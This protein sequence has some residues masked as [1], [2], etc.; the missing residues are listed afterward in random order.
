[1]TPVTRLSVVLA[2]IMVSASALVFAVQA[3]V[4]APVEREFPRYEE[5]VPTAFGDWQA[6]ERSGGVVNPQQ[7]E[8]LDELYSEIVARTYI[9][10]LTGEHIMLSMAYGEDQSRQSQVHRP[11]VCYPAQGFQIVASAKGALALGDTRVPVMRLVAKANAR[12]EPITYWIRVG[13]H[14]VRGYFEQ[15]LATIQRRLAGERSDGLLF[16]VSSIDRNVAAATKSQDRF[17]GDLLRAVDPAQRQLLIGRPE[18]V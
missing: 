12:V 7:Q 14:V 16:R 15:K 13:D 8:Q 1:M 6:T 10:R 9:N 18:G 2:F 5:I 17:V 3:R 4:G 11:E